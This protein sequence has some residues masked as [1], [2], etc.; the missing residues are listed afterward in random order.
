MKSRPVIGRS[1][2][3]MVMLA[4]IATVASLYVAG[5]LWQDSGNRV[6]L[7]GEIDRR[8]GQGHSAVTVDDNLKILTCRNQRKKL[9]Q[10]EIK[11]DDVVNKGFV[12][13]HPNSKGT[14]TRNSKRL[15]AVIGIVTGFDGKKNRDAIRK[16]WVP[17]G[18]ALRKLEKEKGI[19]VRFVIGRSPKQGD[20]SDKAIEDENRMKN[21]FLILDKH[22]EA[23]GEVPQKV[24]L[25]FSHAADTWDADFYAKVND[26]I[27]VNLDSLGTMLTAQLHQPH[28]YMGC[29]KSGQVFSDP[30]QKWYE[31]DWWKFGDGKSYFRHASGEILVLSR[32]L[33]QFISI[34]RSNLRTYAYDDVSVGSW[35]IGLDVNYVHDGQFCCSFWT[36]GAFCSIV[37]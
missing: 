16:S 30:K 9:A 12:K 35:L 37:R 28:V 5:R 7:I 33:A 13:K 2:V 25:F 23:P 4:M 19:V 14:V 26:N 10:L 27:Y 1:P 36:P 17:Q 32:V 31:P 18:A 15:L 24:K 8:T 11:L 6:F 20:G 34:N 29:M 22:V 3:A 21:D